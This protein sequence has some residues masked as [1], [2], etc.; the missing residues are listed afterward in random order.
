M[1]KAINPAIVI[2]DLRLLEKSG[3]KSDFNAGS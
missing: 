1:C 2:S 3:G